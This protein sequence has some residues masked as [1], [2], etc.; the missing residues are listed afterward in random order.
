MR[1]D[2]LTS[3]NSSIA[4]GRSIERVAEIYLRKQGLSSV[5]RNYVCR[6]GEIDL[7][8]LHANTLVFVEVRYRRSAEFGG[9]AES[10]TRKK[11][12]RL[13]RTANHFL[14]CKDEFAESTCRFDVVAVHGAKPSYS[15]DWIE[16]AFSA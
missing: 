11:Q 4:F 5:A 9:G 13:I 10:V 12:L 7:V 3:T 15:I 8:M 14:L 1:T 2:A 6:T 16:D